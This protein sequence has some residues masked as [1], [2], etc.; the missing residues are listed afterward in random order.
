MTLFFLPCSHTKLAFVIVM[1]NPQSCKQ[2]LLMYFDLSNY[3]FYLCVKTS[4]KLTN[5]QLQYH[6]ESA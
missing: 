6:A 4:S 2:L 1:V 3:K 5:V